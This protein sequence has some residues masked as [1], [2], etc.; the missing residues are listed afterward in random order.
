MNPPAWLG[1]GWLDWPHILTLGQ[2][3]LITLLLS[4][5]VIFTG[6]IAGVLLGIARHQSRSRILALPHHLIR[7]IPL[8]VQVLFWYFAVG[9]LLPEEWMLWLN[10][11]HVLWQAGDIFLG[12]PSFEFIAA[13]VA[14]SLYAMAFIAEDIRSGMN[15]VGQGQWNAGR[16]LGLRPL[17]VLRWVIW[18]QAIKTAWPPLL[19]QWL[20]TIKN[21]SLTMAI[22]VMELS[23]RSRQIDAQTLLTFQSFA[24]ASV[25]YVLLIV[26]VQRTLAGPVAKPV[27]RW[28]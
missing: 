14:L 8:L 2:G 24:V 13:W 27:R 28:V 20:N 3:L 6:T 16:A 10:S 26:L 12:L 22:G 15:A 17:D 18:P 23:Y 19:G 4:V 21:T 1:N 5:A 7:N 25:F 9:S 11:P